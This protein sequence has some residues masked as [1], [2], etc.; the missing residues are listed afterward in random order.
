MQPRKHW[1]IW[2]LVAVYIW[3]IFRNSLMIAD[4][5]ARTSTE[6]AQILLRILR[7]FGLYADFE[8]FHHYVRKCAH[9]AEFAGLGFLVTLAMHICPLFRSRFLNFSLFLILVPAADETIQRFVEGRGSA[10]FDMVIDGSGFLF[11]GFVCYVCL[12][13]L[14]DLFGNRTQA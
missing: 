13:I 4:V 1:W 6:A 2:L 14:K 3:M 5:S 12:L 8:V 7:H 10:Y 11:G 9:F